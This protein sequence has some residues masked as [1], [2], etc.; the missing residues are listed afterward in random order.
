MFGIETSELGVDATL[1]MQFEIFAAGA[2]GLK[3]R[4]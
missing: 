2:V 3:E 4:D 1:Y